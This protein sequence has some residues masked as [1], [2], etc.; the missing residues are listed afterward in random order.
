MERNYS[1]IQNAFIHFA[2]FIQKLLYGIV[3]KT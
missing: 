1:T 3:L 2:H